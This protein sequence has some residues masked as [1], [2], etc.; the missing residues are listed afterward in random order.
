ME[1][2]P[3][4]IGR[5]YAAVRYAYNGDRRVIRETYYG[6]DGAPVAMAEGYASVEKDYDAGG[7]TI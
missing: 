2:Q 7:N 1:G 3:V 4:T 6:S 5:D